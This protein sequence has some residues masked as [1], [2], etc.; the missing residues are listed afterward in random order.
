M[1]KQQ[2]LDIPHYV[3]IKPIVSVKQDESP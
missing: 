3:T 2:L 1:T